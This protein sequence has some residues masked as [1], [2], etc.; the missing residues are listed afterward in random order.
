MGIQNNIA[1]FHSLL[2]PKGAR[3][4]CVSKTHPVSLIREAYDA[5]QRLF[6]ENKVQEMVEKQPQLPAD[7]EWHLIGH[8][9][10]NKVKYVAPFV[11]LIH[12]V[13]SLRLLEEIN[14]QGARCGRVI[15]CL[16]QVY[17]ATEETKFGLDPAEVRQIVSS[18][19]LAA[20]K[21]VRVDGLMGMASLTADKVQVQK[22][23]HTLKALF[24]ELKNAGLPPNVH[25]KELSMGMSSDYDIALNEGSTLV[26]IGT[27]I[28]GEREYTTP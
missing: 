22:E 25:M 16:L 13:D 2:D 17:I 24:D 3:L 20:M 18:A 28:F 1:K 21:N 7:I 26:R 9:Q 14:K 8:L 15:P 19:E 6:G 10:R 5:G 12:A 4:I 27:A 23:F 11:A